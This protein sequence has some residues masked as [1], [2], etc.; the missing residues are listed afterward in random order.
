MWCVNPSDC[1][2]INKIIDY[3]IPPIHCTGI[4]LAKILIGKTKILGEKVIK[5]DECM[6]VS[7]YLLGARAHGCP[8]KST[9]MIHCK[10]SRVKAKWSLKKNAYIYICYLTSKVLV[11][12]VNCYIHRCH[13]WGVGVLI[14]Q[15]LGWGSWGLHEILLYPIMYRNMNTFQSS[16]FSEIDRFVHIK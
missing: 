7:Q 5:S 15:I 4:D 6:G 8:P 12:V 3:E 2:S 1:F 13:S 16:H 9:P 11:D 14:P 10:M